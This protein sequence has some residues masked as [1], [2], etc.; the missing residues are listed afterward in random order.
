LL[1]KVK[2]GTLKSKYG[3]YWSGKIVR[4]DPGFLVGAVD[5]DCH[6]ASSDC[7]PPEAFVEAELQFLF[8]IGLRSNIEQFWL[9][10]FAVSFSIFRP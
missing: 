8:R 1:E 2:A 5:S 7:G 6:A 10:V 9:R 3:K 4:C